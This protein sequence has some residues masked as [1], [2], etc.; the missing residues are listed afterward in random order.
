[1]SEQAP[2]HPDL[3]GVPTEATT[4]IVEAACIIAER[5]Q[6][7]ISI[8][9]LLI[10]PGAVSKVLELLTAT[11]GLRTATAA[12]LN[13]GSGPAD[14]LVAQMLDRDPSV[15]SEAIQHTSRL[16]VEGRA[17]QRRAARRAARQDPEVVAQRRDSDRLT[18]LRESRDRARG[19]A[20]TA[21]ADAAALRQQVDE[22]TDQ[23]QL[24]LAELDGTRE[25]LRVQQRR[26]AQPQQA[27]ADMLAAVQVS[28]TPPPSQ[29][30]SDARGVGAGEP[31]RVDP[32]RPTRREQ[33]PPLEL[34]AAAASAGLGAEVA[35]R[36]TE[37]FPRLLKA[38]ISPLRPPAS[39][40]ADRAM[41]VDVLGGGQEI[42]GS[43]V[44]VTA[45]STRLLVDA[46]S[47]PGGTDAAT[48][49]PRRIAHA[50]SGPIEAIVITHAHNDHAGWV[51]ALLKA[52][53]DITI[54]TT[55]ATAS[56]LTTMW[57]D[58]AKVLGHRA[59]ADPV[60][61]ATTAVYSRDDVLHALSRVRVVELGANVRLGELDVELFPA[62]HI[63]GAAGVVVSAGEDRVVISG[64]VSRPGQRSVGGIVLPEGAKHARLLLLESTYAGQARHVPR[65]RAVSDFIADISRAL[66]QGG[67][68]LVPAFALG[69]AQE[70]ALVLAEH[71]PDTPVLI[72][73]LARD[74]SDVYEKFEGPDGNRLRI[75]GDQVRPVRRGQTEHEIARLSSGVI[76]ATSGMLTAGPAVSWAASILP[77][78]TD[79]IMVVGY[80]DE[81]SPGARLL[82]LAEKG[83]GVFELPGHNGGPVRPVPVHAHVGKYGLGAH[84]SADELVTI[85]SEAAA[86]E[87]MLV[88]GERHN[89][90]A[91]AARLDLRNQR[92]VSA[93]HMWSAAT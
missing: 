81:E 40:G 33:T 25:R 39:A 80:Q 9:Q 15:S 71:L 18:E 35:A 47:R 62:G 20:A 92:T 36:A 22:L 59:E 76:I 10:N 6:Q 32:L 66:D 14:L 65:E 12:R 67:R 4:A 37:W 30:S 42:G 56:L 19:R 29:T 48:L 55:D 13:D 84:A 38:I 63:V 1:M 64:D 5:S 27:A 57:L 68:V 8:P 91:F 61:G 46:G 26:A 87:V 24:L 82:A 88:H 51:P 89:Q 45:G 2:A 72:D 50:T 69:R 70:V 49:A 83:G 23:V 44:L 7:P 78:P 54:V 79:A 85:A 52:Q 31:P 3:A 60:T 43:C 77:N 21:A 41:V 16:L 11:R 86:E 74:V 75:F 93:A 53:P 17:Q 58:S 34:E 28:L 90:Q 73:G